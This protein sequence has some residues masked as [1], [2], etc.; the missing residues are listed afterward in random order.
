MHAIKVIVLR[1]GEDRGIA[2]RPFLS[3]QKG[4]PGSPPHRLVLL[5]GAE[6]ARSPPA[7]TAARPE[8]FVQRHFSGVS[9]I[10]C[11]SPGRVAGPC[12][13]P[14]LRT[15]RASA[16]PLGHSPHGECGR[17]LLHPAARTGL[18]T[19]LNCLSK[20]NILAL[21]SVVLTKN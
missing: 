4:D 9:E 8:H 13:H 20:L 11:L 6:A 3:L 2:P 12:H 1:V 18:V 16:I 21:L 19:P 17:F 14:L 5:R 7:C 15:W 10:P